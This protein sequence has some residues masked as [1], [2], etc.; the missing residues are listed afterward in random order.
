MRKLPECC[1][2][3]FYADDEL[4]VCAL[5]PDGIAQGND[6]CSDFDTTK[7]RK[8]KENNYRAEYK[9]AL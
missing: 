7:E 9:L 3:K 4:L 5:H 2:C 1:R 8:H 6:T